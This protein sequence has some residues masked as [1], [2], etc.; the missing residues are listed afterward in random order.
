MFLTFESSQ[1]SDKSPRNPKHS[2]KNSRT[3]R[4]GSQPRACASC[5]HRKIKCDGQKP[6]EAC[7]WYRKPEQCSYPDRQESQSSPS[8]SNTQSDKATAASSDYRSTLARL[9]PDKS[10]ETIAHMSREELLALMSLDISQYSQPQDS[11]ANNPSVG[12]K[13]STISMERPDLESLHSI[14]G[15]ALEESQ[16]SGTSDS[17]GHISDDV[18][19]LSLTNRNPTSYLGVSSIQA[20]LKVIAWLHPEFEAYFSLPSNKENDQQ[21]EVPPQPLA[22]PVSCPAP[23]EIDM[24]NAYFTD[25]HPFAPLIDEENF[26]QTYVNGQRRDNRWLSLLNIVLALGNIAASGSGADNQMHHTYFQRAM[27]QLNLSS[28]GT[29]SLEVTQALGLMGGWYCHYISQPNLGYSL[30]GAALRMAMTL[31]L[32][33]EPYDNQLSVNPSKS[34]AQEGKRRI[35]WS[36]CCLEIWGLETLGRP[37]MD[38]FG[39]GITVNLPNLLDKENYTKILALTENVQFVRI[40]TKIH[41]LLASLPT[42]KYAEIF[43]IDSQLVQWWNNL[44]PIL[45]DYEPCPKNIYTVRTVMRWRF[46]NQRMLLYRPTLLNYAIRRIPFMAIRAEER[47]AIERC[48]EIAKSCI[49]DISITSPMNNMIGW[50]AVWLLFQATMVP[51]VCLSL[52]SA[53]EVSPGLAEDCKAQV[54]TAILTLDRLKL[55]GHTA[56]RSREVISRILEAN[57]QTPGGEAFDAS[58]SQIGAQDFPFMNSLSNPPGVGPE[59]VADRMNAGIGNGWSE[60]MWEYLGWESGEFWPDISRLNAQTEGMPFLDPGDTAM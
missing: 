4:R 21:S 50:N 39:P 14:P 40:A 12:T 23:T 48:H 8:H 32:Q 55:Y 22:P 47:A 17:I 38:C 44:P 53:H 16:S 19:A 13:A 2:K 59:S 1:K 57:L 56:E 58:A 29:P 60:S 27:N 10:P 52:N 15:E 20:A 30:M 37:S 49:H 35:W 24:L 6:C 33:R 9:F 51:L 28:L 25:F 41:A 26:R 43:D 5:R 7:R 31:G 54:E 36:L 18:N 3:S 45:K 42:I 46:F 34:F 11:P